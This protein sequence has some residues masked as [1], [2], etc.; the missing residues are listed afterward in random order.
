MD[1]KSE[2]LPCPFCWGVNIN[3]NENRMS[4]TMQ[5]PKGAL[6][7][8]EITHMCNKSG[9]PQVV[10]KARGSD[11]EQAIVAWNTRAN[12]CADNYIII[13]RKDVPEGLREALEWSGEDFGKPLPH[14][15][16]LRDLIKTAALVAK[17]MEAK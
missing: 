16:Q 13:D 11:T 12:P 15:R 6:I 10:I 5:N 7:S 8:T 17:H 3:I 1:N 9:L 14:P 2:L 4:P